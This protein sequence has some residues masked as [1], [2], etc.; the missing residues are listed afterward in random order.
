VAVKDEARLKKEFERLKDANNT[1]EISEED[2]E[3]Q[4]L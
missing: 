1:I 4:R 2:E 3:A